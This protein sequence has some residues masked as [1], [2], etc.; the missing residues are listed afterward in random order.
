M[1]TL[2]KVARDVPLVQRRSVPAQVS[3]APDGRQLF[4]EVS[5]IAGRSILIFTEHG[6]LGRQLCTVVQTGTVHG[7]LARL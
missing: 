2:E 7:P 5:V 6:L 1:Y 3:G 4:R